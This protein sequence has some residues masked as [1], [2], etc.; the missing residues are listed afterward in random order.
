MTAVERPA[1]TTVAHDPQIEPLRA[2]R[3]ATCRPSPTVLP[4]ADDRERRQRHLASRASSAYHG[5]GLEPEAVRPQLGFSP[6]GG[7]RSPP[8]LRGK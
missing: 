5:W 2:L 3:Q 6:V 1:V 8:Q 4:Q 7:I